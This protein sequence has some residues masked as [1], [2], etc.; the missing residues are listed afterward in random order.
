[1]KRKP[2]HSML[3]YLAVTLLVIYIVAPFLWLIIMSVSSNPDLTT[4]PLRWIPKKIDWSN[5]SNLLTMGL[6]TRG[7]AF[8]YGLRNSFI[9]AFT[10]TAVS[11]F[12]SF[13]AA[14]TFSRQKGKKEIILKIAI[15][16]FML[17]PIAYAL[18]IY[19]IL[20][21][22]GL[23]NNS[24]SLAIVYC[25]IITPFC[26]WL[27]KE[28][29]ESVPYEI[30]EAALIDGAGLFR[31]WAMVLIPLMLPAIGTVALLSMILSWDE[32]FYALLYTSDKS[33]K[34]LPVVISNLASGRQSQYGLIAAGG[35]IAALPP[36]AIGLLLQRYLIRGLTLGSVKG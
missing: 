15:M 28:N 5:Y 23:L 18:P 22:W 3:I 36:V 11:L 35:V 27:T 8:L 13:P 24:F 6:N 17:P 2:I 20:A 1:M 25:T 34:T 30:E 4:K 16:M 9:T 12:V 32:F 14:W 33:A 19:R 29:M 10:A 26:V 21:G 7:E 31:R